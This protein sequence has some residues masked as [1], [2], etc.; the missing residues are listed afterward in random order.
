MH[1]KIIAL[2]GLMLMTCH[3]PA[4]GEGRSI[5]S[6]GRLEPD[7]GIIKVAG[8]S[9]ASASGSVIKSLTVAEGDW[10]EKDQTIAYLDNYTLRKAEVARL[11]AI[12]VNANSELKRQKNLSLT[13]A[14]SKVKLDQATMAL[15]IAKADLAAAKARL[16]L[17]VV[18]SPMRAQIIEIHAQPGE[19]V[20]PEGIMELGQTDRMF[21][22]AEIYETDIALIKE[23]QAAIVRVGAIDDPL[24][25]KVDRISLKV[26]RL[27][28]LG[29]DPVAKTDARVVE[30]YIALDDGAAVAGYTNMQVE[31]EIQI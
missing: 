20:G 31:V 30:V 6:L 16:D 14:T 3:H 15:D 28:I 25:G 29:T 13:S 1:R 7:G 27:D 23:G 5:S 19:R 12:Y 26:G 2:V 10:V 11:Q 24:S 21:V 17:A 4:L 8:P 22:V 9:S 18:R